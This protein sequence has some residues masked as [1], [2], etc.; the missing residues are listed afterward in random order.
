MK[1]TYKC[2]ICGKNFKRLGNFKYHFIRK[3]LVIIENRCPVCKR[4]F[5]NE[6]ALKKHIAFR[7]D[8]EHILYAA[9]LFTTS[10]SKVTLK[11]RERRREAL[12]RYLTVKH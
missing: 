10:R 9:I 5:N 3:H 7:K 1:I 6:Y 11:E 2:P 12:R 8:P 4:Q